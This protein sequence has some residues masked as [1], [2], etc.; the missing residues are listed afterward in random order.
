VFDHSVS[1]AVFGATWVMVSVASALIVVVVVDRPPREQ[2]FM[3]AKPVTYLGRRSYALYLW[4]YVW[5]TWFARFGLVGVV[6]AFGATLATSET[7]WQLVEQHALN[8]K[9]RFSATPRVTRAET[10]TD[11][12]PSPVPS[13]SAL[14]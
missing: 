12:R 4:H 9:R 7:S 3:V 13:A 11:A 14:A 1:V 5:L 10:A 8:L 2:S 6:A